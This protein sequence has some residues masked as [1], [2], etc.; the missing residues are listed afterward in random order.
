MRNLHLTFNW[1]YTWD[2]SK[3]KISQ[4][5]V[6]FSEYMNFRNMSFSNPSAK[7]WF[8]NKKNVFKIV[9]VQ[10]HLKIDKS[11]NKL[12]VINLNYQNQMLDCDFINTLVP[13]CEGDA[14]H[15]SNCMIQQVSCQYFC[16]HNLKVSGLKAEKSSKRISP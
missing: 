8:P 9:I 15:I 13:F 1:N 16:T 7:T 2:K 14:T 6:A 11:S 3:V 5:C 12:R 10:L 4:N